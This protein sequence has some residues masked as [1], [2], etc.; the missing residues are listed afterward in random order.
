MCIINALPLYTATYNGFH[1]VAK[2][3]LDC[4]SFI[5]IFYL[6][7]YILFQESDAETL[8]YAALQFTKRKAKAEK[9]KTGSS[10]DCIYSIV[11]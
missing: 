9:K 8:N 10:E 4:V 3:L 2:I 5:D 1:P 11:K 6:L 7:L